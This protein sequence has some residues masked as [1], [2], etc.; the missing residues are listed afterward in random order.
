MPEYHVVFTCRRRRDSSLWF[1][2]MFLY[3]SGPKYSIISFEKKQIKIQQTVWNYA[4]IA[5]LH[6]PNLQWPKKEVDQVKL[7]KV[8]F[9]VLFL[10]TKWDHKQWEP[11]TLTLF[12][13]AN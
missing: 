12:F 11:F 4:N 13:L 6:L 3:F 10:H 8:F 2:K 7:T 1:S 5:N 9:R